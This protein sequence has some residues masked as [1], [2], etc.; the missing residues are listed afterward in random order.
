MKRIEIGLWESSKRREVTN[1]G[2]VHTWIT[3]PPEDEEA[4]Q[5]NYRDDVD[6]L[7]GHPGPPDLLLS[8]AGIRVVDWKPI[9]K[10]RH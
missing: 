4:E 8:D 1:Y 10:V 9:I 2:V 7:F 5:D 3:E 6:P